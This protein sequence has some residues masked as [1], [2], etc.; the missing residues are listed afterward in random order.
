MTTDLAA[1]PNKRRMP[2]LSGRHVLGFAAVILVGAVTLVPVIFLM[3]NSLNTAE[4]LRPPVIG[5]DNWIRALQDARIWSSIGWT[6]F[7]AVIRVVIAVVLGVLFAW[8]IARTDMP[9]GGALEF[10]FWIAF[11]VPAL[12]LT[13]GWILLLDPRK[14]LINELFLQ[15]PFISAAPFD[16]FT[17]QGIIWIHLTATSIPVAVILI[18]PAFRQLGAALEE[19]ARMCGASALTTLRKITV[20]LLVPAILPAAIIMLIRSLEAFE[21][22][23]VIGGQVK[24]PIYVFSTRIYDFLDLSPPEYGMATALGGLFLVVLFALAGLY[25]YYIRS[26]RFT[27]ITGSGFSRQKVKLGRRG[28]WIAFGGVTGYLLVSFVLSLSFLL[29]GSFMTRF[30]FFGIE[31]VYTTD[32]WTELFGDPILWSSLKNTLILGGVTAVLGVL[33]FSLFAYMSVRSSLPGRRAVELMVWIPW[34]VPGILLGLALLWLYLGTPLGQVIYGTMGGLVLAML[35]KEMPV[36]TQLLKAG[37][38][39][40]GNDLEEAARVTGATWTRTYIKI[41]LPLVAPI[42][43]NVAILSFQGAVRDIGTVIFLYSGSSRPLSILLLEYS[44]SAERGRA[45]AVGIILVVMITIVA[46][47][48]RRFGFRAAGA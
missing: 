11:F 39:Q 42:A 1:I 45:A 21:I 22:E 33:L 24:P 9:G 36:G 12:P 14:G 6:V 46:F 37:F 16:I 28:R 8:L 47:F 31:N 3:Y 34:A 7:L 29:L 13:L 35:I 32:H 15:L 17:W 19:S 20:P 26:R 40:I 27:T 23:L 25:I 38:M 2:R 48:A 4:P 5:L 44:F 41:L 18:T 43:V 10:M 30:G